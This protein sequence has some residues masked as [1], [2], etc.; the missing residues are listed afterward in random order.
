MSRTSDCGSGGHGFET[1]HS[2]QFLS[3]G[4]R[5]VILGRQGEQEIAIENIM[6][7]RGHAKVVELTMAISPDVPRLATPTPAARA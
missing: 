3:L 6:A 2:P 1:R 7:A 5:L 4:R